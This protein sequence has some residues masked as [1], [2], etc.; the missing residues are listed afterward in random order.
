MTKQNI[1]NN[2]LTILKNSLIITSENKKKLTQKIEKLNEDQ[3]AALL[4]IL[5]E[6]EEKQIFIIQEIQKKNPDF[7][8][9]LQKITANEIKKINI[10]KEKKNQKSEEKE[11]LEIEKLL[12]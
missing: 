4:I 5:E 7:L 9:N 1:K 10:K 3:L 6:A 2:V 12:T 11:L 8:K